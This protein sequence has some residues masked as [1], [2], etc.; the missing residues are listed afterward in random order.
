MRNQ[1]DGVSNCPI[2]STFLAVLT[3]KLYVN[4]DKGDSVVSIQNA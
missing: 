1:M 2:V 3:S 4:E